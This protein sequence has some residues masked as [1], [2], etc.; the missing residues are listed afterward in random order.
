MT[1]LTSGTVVLNKQ[2]HVLEEIVGSALRRLHRELESHIVYVNIPS[3]IPLLLL[4]GVLM[5]QAF[6]NLLE[7][8]A[9]YAPAGSQ[10]EIR[11]RVQDQHVEIRV[12]DNG[13]G[14]P[15]GSESRVF[16]KFFRGSTARSDGRRGAGLGLAICQAIIAAHGGRISARNRPGGGA[17]FI[18]ALPCEEAAPR[19]AVEEVPHKV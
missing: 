3:D 7:N 13:P 14:L 5:E 2:W 12:A 6:F 8:A 19:V 9:R 11:A 16:E 15:P 10:V 4:D 17:E 18:L 1:R